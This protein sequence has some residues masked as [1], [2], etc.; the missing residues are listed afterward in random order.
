[1]TRP[2]AERT[3]SVRLDPAQGK[4]GLQ[5]VPI[6]G[7]SLDQPEYG[8]LDSGTL[9]AVNIT[10]IS[11]TGSV[12]ELKVENTLRTRVFLMDGQELI[13]AKQ[14]RILNTD[15]LVPAKTTLT[16]PVSC[17]EAGRWHYSSPSFTPGK[18]ASHRVRSGK[19]ERVYAA[20]RSTGYHDADQS[21]VWSEVH[22]TLMGSSCMSS[23]S[24]LH[25]AYEA[26]ESN[27]TDFRSSLHLPDETVGL[28]IFCN[29]RFQGL[30]L[31]DRCST[32]RYFWESLVDSYAID[33]LA[34]LGKAVDSTVDPAQVG[35]TTLDTAM[36]GN[37]EVFPSPGEGRDYRLSDARLTGSCLV[38]E[39]KS[40]VHLQLFP[41][42]NGEGDEQARVWRPRIHR[43]YAGGSG[44]IG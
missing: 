10:E 36:S 16:L 42:Q 1:M 29:G 30:D 35:Q 24:S 2:I 38:W 22:D 13:G 3:G 27:L 39:E 9:P 19:Q 4:H 21:A 32:L 5:V 23:T 31:F 20:L 14:N 33:W 44:R 43:P 8:L 28:A 6:L 18:T 15:V 40:A 26:Q 11:S 7:I 12:P 25:D 41:R 34:R 37:W 17:V